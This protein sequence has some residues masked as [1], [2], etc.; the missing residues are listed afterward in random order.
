MPEGPEVKL[1]TDCLNKFVE[2]KKL[3]E[4]R[5]KDNGKYEGKAPNNY[6]EFCEHLPL[7][8]KKVKK[9]GKFMVWDFCRSG[10]TKYYMFNHLMMTGS[11]GLKDDG[12]VA[13]EFFFS[14]CTL[15][16][17]DKRRFGRIEFSNSETKLQEELGKI[18][19]D[20]MEPGI[21]STQFV[22]IMRQSPK[23]NLGVAMM[24]QDKISG[25][26]NYLRAEILY[27]AQISPHKKINEVSDQQLTKIFVITR[28]MLEISYNFKGC[29]LQDFK[30]LEG[31]EGGFQKHLKVYKRKKDIHG[32]EVKIAKIGGRSVYW[33]PQVQK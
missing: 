22:K 30:N 1:I 25:I 24:E 19:P 21:T 3:I 28:N 5:I 26:G 12:F 11:W 13:L 17:S 4:V 16:Y 9:K 10:S 7:K 8:V 31:E 23:K 32:N 33:V 6:K 14:N 15:Y 27:A 18:G 2:G 29:S 20:M